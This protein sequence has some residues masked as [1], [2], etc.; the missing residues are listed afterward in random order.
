MRTHYWAQGWPGLIGLPIGLTGLGLLLPRLE[1]GTAT[2]WAELL[3]LTGLCLL[4]LSWLGTVGRIMAWWRQ[5]RGTP[6]PASLRLTDERLRI[7]R[8]DTVAEYAWRYVTKTT[9]AAGCHLIWLRPSGAAI[10]LPTRAIPPELRLEVAEF[11]RL[12]GSAAPS[13]PAPR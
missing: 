11:L 3:L 8:D 12:R 2:G 10:A 13:R 1:P 9:E 5:V 6:R 7:E 4:A